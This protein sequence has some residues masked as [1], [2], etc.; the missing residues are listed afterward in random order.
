MIGFFKILLLVSLCFGVFFISQQPD[1][2]KQS[3]I[4]KDLE[5]SVIAW[6]RNKIPSNLFDLISSDLSRDKA[7]SILAE[8]YPHDKIVRTIN[9][10]YQIDDM[11][12]TGSRNRQ[13]EQTLKKLK[14]SGYIDTTV[15]RR[16]QGYFPGSQYN[17]TFTPKLSSYIEGKRLGGFITDV[18]IAESVFNE[19]TG[20]RK[21]NDNEYI[22]EFTTKI[23]PN[24]LSEA[25]PLDSYESNGSQQ[26]VYFVRYDDG[27]RYGK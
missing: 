25:F 19:I 22:V 11:S 13:E 23:V 6:V 18:K 15:I 20:I 3:D 26:R 9:S 16:T 12:P 21:I 5:K 14:E 7:R 2:L 24:P 8:T 1:L 27:W 4:P 10:E 17:V